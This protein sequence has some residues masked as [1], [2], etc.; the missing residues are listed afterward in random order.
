MG[1]ETKFEE[2]GMIKKDK[3]LLWSKRNQV[4]AIT[5]AGAEKSAVTGM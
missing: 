5:S 3:I 4:T 2:L 1:K